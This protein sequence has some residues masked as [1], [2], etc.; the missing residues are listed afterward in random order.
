MKKQIS[1]YLLLALSISMLRAQQD[2]ARYEIL[3]TMPVYFEQMKG[4]LDYPMSYEHSGIRKFS[5]WKEVA[6]ATIYDLMQNYPDAPSIYDMKVVA[7]EQRE[8]YKAQKID[9]NISELAR[10]PG[11]LLVPD[12]EGPFPAILMLHDHGAHFSIGKEKMVRPFGVSAEIIEDAE[13]WSIACYDTVFVGDYFARNGYVVLAVDALFWGERGRKEGVN[14]DAQQALNSN[15]VQMGSS[16]G[17]LI[18]IDD[19]RSAE[20]LASLP[21]V[22]PKRVGCLGH[23]MGGFRSWMTAALTDCISVS[24]SVCWICNTDGLMSLGN[25]QTKGGSAYSMM[26]PGLRRYMD[27]DHVAA[28]ACP[29]P[30]LFFNGRN[31]KLFP[32]KYVEQCYDYLNSVWRG[33]NASDRLVTKVWDEKHYFNKAMQKETLDFFDQ[34]LK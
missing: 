20:F 7:E 2:T 10:V 18:N 28:L 19:V 3:G 17:A 25:N 5:K 30:S 32:V 12:G 33:Q 26:I 1:L 14:Y 31:D 24:A 8:G 34:W 21:M 15:L 9:F 13:K 27:Y 22:D 11:Y 23:S 6:R 16:W 29:K 4:K